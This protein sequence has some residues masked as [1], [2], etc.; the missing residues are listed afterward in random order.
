MQWNSD[1]KA[2]WVAIY[3]LCVL[4]LLTLNLTLLVE[5][6]VNLAELLPKLFAVCRASAG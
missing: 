6:N 3:R 4:G 1:P 2:S 5:H